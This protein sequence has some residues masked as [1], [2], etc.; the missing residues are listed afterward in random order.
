[1]RVLVTG[2]AGYIGT[3]V[4]IALAE[5]GHVPVVVDNYVSSDRRIMYRV[6]ELLDDDVPTYEL[7]CQDVARMRTIVSNERI[8]AVVHLAAYKY[9]GESV[10]CPLIYYRNNVGALVATLQVMC[11]MQVR[12]LVFSSS[13]TVYGQPSSMPITEGTPLAPTSPYGRTKRI[14]ED[15]ISDT[16][17][18][19]MIVL[20]SGIRAASLRYFNPIGA[21]PSGRIGEPF[22]RPQTLLPYV[23]KSAMGQCGPLIVHGGDYPTPDGTAIRDY[24]HVVDLADAHAAALRWLLDPSYDV[25]STRPVNEPFNIGTGKGTSVLEV[26]QSFIDATGSNVTYRIDRRRK[27]DVAEAYAD[28]SKAAEVLGWRAKLDLR[29]AMADAWRWQKSGGL[30]YDRS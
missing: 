17:A 8:D 26:V 19:D 30:A 3:H 11:D 7:E 28:V 13:C 21:H 23:M 15:I 1:M 16:I 20:G 6:R 2:G 22:G 27:G 12:K 24:L 25:L 14:C 9:V 18:G 5:A 4:C 10:D 29:T